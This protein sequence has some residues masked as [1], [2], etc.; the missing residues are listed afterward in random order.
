[1]LLEQKCWRQR[2]KLLRNFQTEIVATLVGGIESVRHL[3]KFRKRPTVTVTKTRR[4]LITWD[5]VYEAFY[6]RNLGMLVI[7]YSTC[8]RQAFPV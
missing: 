8:L 6:V 4:T 3:A 2:K 1:M 7:S 5:T